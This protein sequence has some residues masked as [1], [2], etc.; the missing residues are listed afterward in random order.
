MHSVNFSSCTV[1]PLL[2]SIRAS[3]LVGVLRFFIGHSTVTLFIPLSFIRLV[4]TAQGK[5]HCF[6]LFGNTK[7]KI[8]LF[9]YYIIGISFISMIT[10]LVDV[11]LAIGKYSSPLRTS[12]AVLSVPVSF[13]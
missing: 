3:L 13:I 7:L 5:A 12:A 6:T 1:L 4:V 10:I 11:H 9:M 8:E 2:Q